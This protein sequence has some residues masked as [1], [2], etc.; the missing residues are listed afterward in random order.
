MEEFGVILLLV[1]VC[2]GLA[3]PKIIAIV[4]AASYNCKL[5]HYAQCA[6]QNDDEL[7]A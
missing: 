1:L 6:T 4:M 5:G 2:I 3:F 7:I